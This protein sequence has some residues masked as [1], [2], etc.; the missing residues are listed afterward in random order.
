MIS[1][2]SLLVLVELHSSIESKREKCR[3]P[4]IEILKADCVDQAFSSLDFG[5]QE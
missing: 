5:E 1:F 3:D 4:E 2:E